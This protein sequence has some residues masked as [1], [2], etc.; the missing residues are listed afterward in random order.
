MSRSDALVLFGATGDLARK[1][2]YPALYHLTARDRLDLPV[3]GVASS[4]WT[5]QDF[6]DN[7]SR[8]I[9]ATVPHAKAAV[10]A[11]LLERL[12]YVSGSYED[13]ETFSR[14]ARCLSERGAELPTC[15]LAIPPSAFPTVAEGLAERRP[16][17][18]PGGSWWRSRSAGTWP[19]PGS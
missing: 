10:T 9:D 13:P 12:A 14:L 8:A 19:R 5:D 1:K 16:R 6:R 18:R 2:L 11:Q 17:P 15:Y 7:A 4:G 3:I